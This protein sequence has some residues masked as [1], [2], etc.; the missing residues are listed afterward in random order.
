[1][2]SNINRQ[3]EINWTKG[4]FPT[5]A[6]MLVAVAIVLL[7][8]LVFFRVGTF[9][10]SGNVHYSLEDIADASG[11]TEGDILMGVNKTSTASRLLVELPYLEQVIIHKELP[12][13]VRFE[14][15]ECT[16][17]A[18][19]V[20]EFST[21]WTMN[22]K[23]KLLEEIENPDEAGDSA[24]PV[25]SG[26]FLTLPTGG[27][28]AVF[29]DSFRGE[30]SMRV[31]SAVLDTELLGKISE[32]NVEDTEDV[33]LLYEDRIEVHLGEGNEAE[34]KLQYLKAVL[35]ELGDSAS[36]LLDLSFSGGEQ[37]VFHPIV[38]D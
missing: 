5:W 19:C 31:L 9:E 33:Y 1:M 11:I 16:A 34:Y 32:I 23:G 15:Q 7:M 24:Y 25:I 3:K 37:A 36:G 10:V 22:A 4:E 8:M 13:T 2:D 14:V 38:R 35:P 30:L 28:I 12:G 27:D 17:A 18:V 20:S 6:K 26:A 21:Y 29:D